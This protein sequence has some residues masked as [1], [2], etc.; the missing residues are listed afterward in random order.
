MPL[1]VQLTFPVTETLTR[2]ICATATT[3]LPCYPCIMSTAPWPDTALTVTVVRSHLNP[4][5]SSNPTD[6]VPFQTSCSAATEET[7]TVTIQLCSTCDT[8]VYTGTVP[9]YTPGGPCHGCT[10]YATTTVTTTATATATILSSGIGIGSS[11]PSPCTETD[12]DVAE[13]TTTTTSTST[14]TVSGSDCDD[15]G[16]GT[17][18]GTDTSTSTS[19]PP[20]NPGLPASSA[21]TTAVG[22]GTGTGTGTTAATHT[23]SKP[24]TAAPPVV[25]AGGVRSGGVVDVAG[26]VMG[27]AVVG[28]VRLGM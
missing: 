21:T 22:T 20:G 7:L 16:T 26:M 5:P 2:S 14:S 17:D 27:L 1:I 4:H 9:G 15:E 13:T 25:T 24:A 28:V 11:S 6:E 12:S 10:P 18:T 8:S 3:S 19:T 23:S